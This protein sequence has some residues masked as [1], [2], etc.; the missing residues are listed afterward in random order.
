MDTTTKSNLSTANPTNTTAATVASKT[1]QLKNLTTHKL[2]QPTKRF[3]ALQEHQAILA[4]TFQVV[5]G[6]QVQQ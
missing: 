6:Q 1:H 4:A 5:V 2:S 3:G